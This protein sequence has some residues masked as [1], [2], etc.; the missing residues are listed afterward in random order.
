MRRERG[1]EEEG[2]TPSRT[3]N[4][5]TEFMVSGNRRVGRRWNSPRSPFLPSSLGSM[6][7]ALEPFPISWKPSSPS[8]L[9]G[10]VIQELGGEEEEERIEIE[11][12]ARR[13]IS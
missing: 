6:H 1:K 8:S 7:E 11:K 4:K 13:C 9:N 10:A 5:C 3:G 2:L 12:R